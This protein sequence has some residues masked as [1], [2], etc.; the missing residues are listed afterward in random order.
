MRRLSGLPSNQ[1]RTFVNDAAHELKTAVTIIKSSLHC[2]IR[3]LA[4]LKNI[5]AD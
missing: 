2:W 4:R 1:Q 3:D 5:A